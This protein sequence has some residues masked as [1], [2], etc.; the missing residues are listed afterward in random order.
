MADL[1]TVAG[2]LLV[3]ILVVGGIAYLALGD[4]LDPDAENGTESRE[5]I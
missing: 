4:S 3:A 5:E 2:G 1:L